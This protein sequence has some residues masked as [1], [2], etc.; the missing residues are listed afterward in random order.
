[1]TLCAALVELTVCDANVRVLA[2]SAMAGCGA[3]VPVPLRA[4]LDFGNQGVGTT[5]MARSV[6]LANT[7]SGALAIS[8]ISATP[9]FGVSHN[10]GTSLA[11][12]STCTLSVTFTPTTSGAVVGSVSVG[13]NASGSPHAVA[14]S[15]SG[16][17]AS[18]VLA[19]TP[20]LAAI[21][22]GTASV[23]GSGVQQNLTLTN[24]G[25]G[26][27]TLQQLT[28]AGAQAADFAFGGA[29]TCSSGITLATG[30]N[31][32]LVVGFQPGAT[33]ARSATLHVTS[34]G[35]NPP[36]VTLTGTGSST[37]QPSASVMPSAI[38]FA[39]PKGMANAAAQELMV[40]SAGS[41]TLR[42]LALRVAS[43]AFA[44]ETANSQPCQAAPFDLL[45][46]QSCRVAVAWSNP[47]GS[48][49]TG[50]VEI[51]SNATEKPLSV[52][53]MAV[54]ETAQSIS[55]VGAGGC[56][57]SA[58]PSVTDPTLWLLVALAVSVLWQRRTPLPA[59][60]RRPIRPSSRHSHGDRP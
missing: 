24:Q 42:V 23:G 40:E 37:A 32:T 12:G 53:V 47:G 44:L 6:T 51:E 38:N 60:P 8:G 21:D 22:F 3:A 36:D 27:V 30:T 7:G 33:G 35:S 11:A 28:L 2:L 16:V 59:S 50:T 25:P 39:V 34:S 15:G 46:G 18:P 13:S 57:I 31:C 55:N 41:A 14:L 26:S 58:Q 54:R 45:P 5:A 20:A 43:G 56:S 17:T 10:C 1:M 4:T 19:W 29:S 52:P 9:G 48:S 49:E